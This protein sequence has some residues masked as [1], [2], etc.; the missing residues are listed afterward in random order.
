MFYVVFLLAI[1]SRLVPH[2][3]N[4]A[5]IAA[6]GLL[7]GCYVRGS[8]AW[9]LP[10]AAMLVSDVAGHVLAIPGLGLYAPLAM[11]FVYGGM[12]ASVAVGRCLR[13]RPRP[14]SVAAASV[15]SST[16]FF[17][18]SN[19]GV[20]LGGFYAQTP[21]GLLACFTMAVPFYGYTLLGDLFFS[22]T[23]FGTF[24]LLRHRVPAGA[25]GP[26]VLSPSAAAR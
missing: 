15:A 23:L 11:A 12:V 6:L 2:P 8:V 17:L 14:W 13:A 7:A 24:E 26:A 5:C 10:V 25:L 22:A 1:L 3:P 9:V 18:L 19:T 21:A 4:V 20:W 16:L